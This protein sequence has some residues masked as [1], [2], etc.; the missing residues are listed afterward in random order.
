MPIE[1][2]TFLLGGV[3]V[4]FPEKGTVRE[5]RQSDVRSG[6]NAS[7]LV[8]PNA[9]AVTVALLRRLPTSHYLYGWNDRRL[10]T[11]LK[12]SG[13]NKASANSS[14]EIPRILATAS[15]AKCVPVASRPLLAVAARPFRSIA[16][17][18]EQFMPRGW[19]LAAG[20]I[21]GEVGCR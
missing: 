14:S 11:I 3:R 16:T 9:L 21:I 18:F 10:P 7:G 6:T 19:S 1:R 5:K 2:V 15:T 8:P 20:G 13:N 12:P 17:D 4:T